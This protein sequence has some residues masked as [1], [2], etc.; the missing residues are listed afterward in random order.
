MANFISNA[1]LSLVMDKSAR[2]TRERRK[3]ILKD[4]KEG[5]SPTKKSAKK[6][7]KTTKKK[8]VSAKPAEKPQNSAPQPV[9]SAQGKVLKGVTPA[10]ENIAMMLAEKIAR[11][12]D[13]IHERGQ[14]KKTWTGDRG[15]LIV[16]ALRIQ[17]AKADVFRDIDDDQ[18]RKLQGLAQQMM[19][20]GSSK[21]R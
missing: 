13:A 7:A 18:F 9:L 6:S 4:I 5:K 11:A 20:G 3:Q 16:N 15:E 17:K 8:S 10:E 14:K 19:L 21:D 12:E 2:E 1:F